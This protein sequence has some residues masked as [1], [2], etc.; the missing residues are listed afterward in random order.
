VRSHRS[1]RGRITAEARLIPFQVR[2][3]IVISKVDAGRTT[4]L[5]V[6]REV[7]ESA[8]YVLSGKALMLA[9]SGNSCASRTN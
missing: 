9:S 6:T 4:A 1:S 2:F 7:F 5:A 3:E 8:D